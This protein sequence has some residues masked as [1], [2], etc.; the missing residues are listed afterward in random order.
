MRQPGLACKQIQK[1]VIPKSEPKPTGDLKGTATLKK[2][3]EVGGGEKMI[4]HL[5]NGTALIALGDKGK[6]S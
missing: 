5:G 1:Q 3:K 4:F 2:R 6:A